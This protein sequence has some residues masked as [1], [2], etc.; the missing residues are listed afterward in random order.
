MTY[1]PDPDRV[2]NAFYKAVNQSVEKRRALEAVEL[3]RAIEEAKNH[4]EWCERR[5][6]EKGRYPSWIDDDG[7]TLV[8]ARAFLESRNEIARRDERI[9]Y[10][11]AQVE[12]LKLVAADV[13]E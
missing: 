5:F 2:L 9:A 12:A 3:A 6:A 8:I 1:Q 10:L 11:E 13:T 7:T 4:V